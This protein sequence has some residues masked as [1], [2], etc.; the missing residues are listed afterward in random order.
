MSFSAWLRG[1]LKEGRYRNAVEMAEAFGVTEPAVIYWLHGKRRPS[2]VSCRQIAAATG[3]PLPEV[4]LMATI[5]GDGEARE[6]SPA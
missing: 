4:V 6:P 2:V 3:T 1:M 5:G